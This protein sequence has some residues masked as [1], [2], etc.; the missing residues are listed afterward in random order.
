[1][2]LA[3]TADLLPALHVDGLQL[4]RALGRE[5]WSV[6][7]PFGPAGWCIDRHD[8]AARVIVTCAPHHEDG[9]DWRHA[10]ISRPDRMPDYEDLVTLHRAAFG[11]EAWAYQVFAPAGEHVNIH[12]HALHLW[13]RCDGSPALPN[14]G[15][16]GTI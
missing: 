3:E 7:R 2:T 13:G 16:L 6:P 11:E 15:A 5:H 8:R 14:F 4:R 1:V 9:V 12:A 10:S